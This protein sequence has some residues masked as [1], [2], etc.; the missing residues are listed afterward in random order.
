MFARENVP[1][2]DAVGLLNTGLDEWNIFVVNRDPENGYEATL[3]LRSFEAAGTVEVQ[4]LT[5]PDLLTRNDWERP[6]AIGPVRGTIAISSSVLKVNLPPLSLTRY[7]V[8]K[9]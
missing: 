6:D 4:T 5:A 8:R 2:V 3:E 1:Y 9:P 7:T